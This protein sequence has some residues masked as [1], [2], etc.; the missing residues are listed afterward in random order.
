MKRKSILLV[1]VSVLVLALLS[2]CGLFKFGRQKETAPEKETTTMQAETTTTKKEEVQKSG[3]LDDVYVL[4]GYAFPVSSK[5]EKEGETVENTMYF[6]SEDSMTFIMFQT[7]EGNFPVSEK[8]FQDSFIEG[9]SSGID[10]MDIITQQNKELQNGVEAFNLICNGSMYGMTMK[11][12]LYCLNGLDNHFMTIGAISMNNNEEM[13]ADFQEM[14]NTF[15]PADE[16]GKDEPTGDEKETKSTQKNGKIPEA[17]AV[18]LDDS[19]VLMTFKEIKTGV[20]GPEIKVE[21]SNQF[22]RPILVQCDEASIDGYMI[23]ALMSKTLQPGKKSVE[24][25]TFFEEDLE[26]AGIS[27]LSECGELM[28]HIRIMD[29]DSWDELNEIDVTLIA[30]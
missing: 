20:F 11:A 18:L 13:L 14:M 1:L 25:I 3:R 6:Y 19:Y 28:L 10:D 8:V 17:G 15:C 7:T 2:G 30:E 27:D 23:D 24:S 29:D 4:G 12:E 22:D 5:W 16:L 9:F 26:D 21:V